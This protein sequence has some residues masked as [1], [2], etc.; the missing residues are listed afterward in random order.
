[1]KKIENVPHDPGGYR[2]R[3]ET[4]W[5]SPRSYGEW[6]AAIRKGVTPEGVQIKEI[7]GTEI[8]EILLGEREEPRYAHMRRT[9]SSW[10]GAPPELIVVE[11]SNGS[12]R[13]NR[14]VLPAGSMLVVEH[15]SQTAE[16]TRRGV[17]V[18]HH[19]DVVRDVP[20]ED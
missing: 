11:E 3:H 6:L 13:A 4:M 2:T 14:V 20:F 5:K 16:H 10:V 7:A 1:M 18:Y 9:A 15:I 8:I 17:V 19:P 12:W